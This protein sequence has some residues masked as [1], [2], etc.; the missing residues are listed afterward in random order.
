MTVGGDRGDI[1]LGWLTRLTVTIAVLGVLAFDGVSLVKARFSAEDSAQTAARAAAEVFRDTHDVQKAY[2]AAYAVA[3]EHGATVDAPTFRP[4]TDGS[5]TLT[6]R[7]TAPTLV[8]R[9]VPPAR[10]WAD[11]AATVTGRLP[12]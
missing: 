6:L 4:A 3:V 2:D 11:V 12:T 9:R 1:V 10:G 7:E 5:V 8:L